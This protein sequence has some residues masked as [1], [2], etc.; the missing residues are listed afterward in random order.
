MQDHGCA[1]IIEVRLLITKS[2]L[3]VGKNKS[4]GKG[5]PLLHRPEIFHQVTGGSV[6]A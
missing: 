1:V 4:Q 2:V 6:H 5:L 3:P